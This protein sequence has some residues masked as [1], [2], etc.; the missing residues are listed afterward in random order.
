MVDKVVSKIK[1]NPVVRWFVK[2]DQVISNTLEYHV[3]YSHKLASLFVIYKQLV[4]IVGFPIA[5]VTLF[6]LA[7]KGPLLVGAWLFMTLI[8][9]LVLKNIFKRSRPF[10]VDG[11]WSEKSHLFGY[12][13]PSNHAYVAGFF[14]TVWLTLHLPYLKLVLIIFTLLPI[15]RVVLN[16]HFVSDV[17]VGFII[18][19]L[20]AQMVLRWLGLG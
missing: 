15:S 18:G 11:D 1:T 6:F 5:G 13:F 19:I 10:M 4:D 2:I 9:E 16:Y 3:R 7:P 14:V 12:S 17:T 8:N 20:W